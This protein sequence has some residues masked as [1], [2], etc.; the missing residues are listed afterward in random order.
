MS[1]TMSLSL[2]RRRC[3]VRAMKQKPL[4]ARAWLPIVTVLV[5][6]Y[7]ARFLSAPIETVKWIGAPLLFLPT[8]LGVLPSVKSDDV[9]SIGLRAPSPILDI[10]APGQ[11]AVYADREDMLLR[12]NYIATQATPWISI[13]EVASGAELPAFNVQ[14]GAQIW[15]P[16]AVPGRPVVT[17]ALPRAGQYELLYGRQSGEVY[18]APDPVSGREGLLTLLF[19]GQIGIVMAA[20]T[21]SV[22]PRI[23]H[24][25]ANTRLAAEEQK[26]KRAESAE[27]VRQFGGKDGSSK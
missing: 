4:A 25:W 1:K 20:L 8:A 7:I 23:K 22:W 3:K 18:F 14:S 17:F 11:Y 2:Q 27:F 26:R 16:M 13:R 19:A 24:N 6:A 10:P 15:H 21:P 5:L 9:R 12:A